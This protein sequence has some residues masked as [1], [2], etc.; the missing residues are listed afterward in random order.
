MFVGIL[1]TFLV[2]FVI[3]VFSLLTFRSY[4]K[5]NSRYAS[6]AVNSFALFWLG[7]AG[8]WFSI[9]CMDFFRYLGFQQVAVIGTYCL[10][11]FIG[12]SIVVGADFIQVVLFAGQKRKIALTV[13]GIWYL[14][15]LVSL[16]FYKV[17]PQPEN[18]FAAQ[19]LSSPATLGLFIVG[20]FPL[21]VG[22]VV[23]FVRSIKNKIKLP[24]PVRH[25]YLFMA[26]SLILVGLAGALDETGIV[27]GWMV[28]VMRLITLVSSI[29]AYTALG[30]LRKPDE[31]VI[32]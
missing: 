29:V 6:Q 28:T 12:A 15:F 21:W 24:E 5:I 17:E 25:S 4:Y 16:F 20:S 30:G 11:I 10:Q 13:Y 14:F 2:S 9:A 7:M 1:F 18:Y 32:E 31:M 8:S 3:G 26:V 22:A 27:Y 19:I 23:L